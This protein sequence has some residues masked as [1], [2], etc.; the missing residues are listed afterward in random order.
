MHNLNS[1]H[2]H[3][4]FAYSSGNKSMKR[5]E[6]PAKPKMGGAKKAKIEPMEEDLIIIDDE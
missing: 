4:C 5:H 3:V 6:S 2:N 1:F